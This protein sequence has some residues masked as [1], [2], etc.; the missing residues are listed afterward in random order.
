M[1]LWKSLR[2]AAAALAGLLAAGGLWWALREQT[3]PAE[4][5][6][7]LP[8]RAGAT[9][10]ID[11]GLARKAGVLRHLS[12][13]E[14]LQEPDYRA[15]VEASGFDYTRDL[16][17]VALRF[18]QGGGVWIAA[19]GRFDAAKLAAYAQARGGRCL[20]GICTMPGSAAERQISWLEPTGRILSMAVAPDPLAAA[21][22]GGGKPPA[23]RLPDSPVWLH[24]PA[25]LL[26]PADGL[27]PGTSALLSALEGAR[28]ARFWVDAGSRGVVVR[29]NAPFSA[30]EPARASA[31]RLDNA[32]ALLK[33]LIARES[34]R[35]AAGLGGILASGQFRAQG[36]TVE[37]S[38]PVNETFLKE[39]TR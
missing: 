20:R 36:S 4:L 17:A 7:A 35:A 9:L 16:D 13:P 12:A 31:A 27:P 14:A 25:S 19:A 29:L 23:E 24:V 11:A 32:T 34:P 26:T 6:A 1:T 5:L 22:S 18:A 2:L 10:Y 30:E 38:W 39:L 15:F 37:G 3:A 28:D 8:D 33:K 21:L